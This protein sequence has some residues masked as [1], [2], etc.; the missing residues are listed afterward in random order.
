MCPQPYYQP[1]PVPPA[2]FTTNSAY[3]PTTLGDSFAWALTVQNSQNILL[4]GTCPGSLT[5]LRAL[6]RSP[7][8]GFYSFFNDYN[9]ACQSSQNCQTQIVNI[10]SSSTIGIY[11]LTTVD[12]TW[13]LSVNN[14]G[15]IAR[16]LNPNGF[17]DTVSAWTRT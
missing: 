2:P 8:A 15:V 10:D 6:T 13:Q 12:T 17:A 7:G 9:T 16:S 14:A 3:D 1:N 5:T 4:F 11:S